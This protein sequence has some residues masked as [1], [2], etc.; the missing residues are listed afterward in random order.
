LYFTD[1][2]DHLLKLTAI[3]ESN[4]EL[5]SDMRDHY[6]SIKA[7]RMNSIMLTL[8]VVTVIFMPLTFIAGIYGMNFEYMPELKWHYGYF[9]VLGL[10]A[11]VGVSMYIW[12]KRKGWLE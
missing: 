10:M 6:M 11:I 7:D 3:I 2:Y 5:T 1:I 4:R 12:F 9:A 8:T